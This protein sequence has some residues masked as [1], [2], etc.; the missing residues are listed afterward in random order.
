MKIQKMNKKLKFSPALNRDGTKAP[1]II[2]VVL[3]KFGT[4]SQVLFI[5]SM[6]RQAFKETKRTGKVVLYSR[7]RKCLW[8][9]GATSGDWLKVVGY[10]VN[11]NSDSL[12]ISVIPVKGVCH[13]KRPCGKSWHTCFF[14]ELI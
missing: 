14:T 4:R 6:S 3:V 2:D 7:S 11:C 12:L 8:Y 1:R 5:A 13:V 9:K 10:K